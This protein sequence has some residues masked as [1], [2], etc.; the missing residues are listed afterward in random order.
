VQRCHRRQPHCVRHL[1]ERLHAPR[2]RLQRRERLDPSDGVESCN[3]IDDDCDLATDEGVLLT[4][5]RDSD[6]DGF[7]ALAMPTTACSAPRCYVVLGT[8]CADTNAALNPAAA[9]RCDGVNNDC[10]ATTDE[11]CMCTD[12]ASMPCG[13]SSVG[14]CRRGTQA[15]ISGT[16]SACAGNV[17]PRYRPS[18]AMASTT[19]TATERVRRGADATCYADADGDAYGTGVPLTLCRNTARPTFGNCP[20]GYTGPRATATMETRW[21]VR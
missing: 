18:P 21:C 1:P 6:G 15:C 19:T 16:W 17:E 4:Y 2:R 5:Y 12:G 8:D 11:G 10:D 13:T 20:V 7:G 14:V 9:E 3:G